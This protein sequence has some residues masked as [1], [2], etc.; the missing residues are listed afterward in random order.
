ML[1]VVGA[2]AALSS[3]GSAQPASSTIE[4]VSAT[5]DGAPSTPDN[6][7][8]RVS[9]DG[10][11]VVFD[12]SLTLDDPTSTTSTTSTTPSPP[13]APVSTAVVTI[14]NRQA[15]TTQR[16][17]DEPSLHPGVSGNG[18]VVAYSVPVSGGQVRLI[19]L[20]RCTNPGG[21]LIGST[22]VVD[23]VTASADPTGAL[24]APALSDDGSVIVWSTGR[25]ITRYVASSTG[26]DEM[27]IPMPTS[28]V[29][30]DPVATGSTVDVSDDGT[31]VVFVAGPGS[32][33]YEPDPANV[34]AWNDDPDDAG[35]QVA[36]T[37]LV[38][39]STTGGPGTGDSAWPSVSGNGRIV[40]Y[41]SSSDDIDASGSATSQTPFVVVVDR[42]AGTAD[43]LVDD[44]SRP[45]I[46]GDGT[47]V[48]HD[49]PTGVELQRWV[50]GGDTPFADT[51]EATLS[52][53]VDG[54]TS[55]GPSVTGPVVSGDGSVAVFDHTSGA[56]LTTDTRFGTGAH[57]WAR[58]T[59]QDEPAVTTTTPGAPG[60][61]TTTPSGGSAPP[62][63]TATR[64]SLP[65]TAGRPPPTTIPATTSSPGRPAPPASSSGSRPPSASGSGSSGN[66]S[67]P[68]GTGSTPTFSTGP[69]EFVAFV[70][71]GVEF[72]PTIVDAGRQTATFSVSNPT[73]NAV[74]VTAV[75]FDGDPDGAFSV[76]ENAC[77]ASPV[78][79]AG[80]CDLA[81][82]YAPVSDGYASAQIVA[83]LSDGSVVYGTVAGTGAPPPVVSV[84]PGV[85][86][87]GQVV[88]I[89]GS[90]FPA[91]V[92]IELSWLGQEPPLRIDVDASGAFVE[93]VIVMSHTPRGPADVTV[94]GQVD[95]F[96][97]VAGE[98]LI[99]D[100][101]DRSSSTLTQTAGGRFAS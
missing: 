55:A 31:V 37:E 24:A 58:P 26:Y 99:T 23:T 20:D 64:P 36:A 16:V 6:L 81:V 52:I 79:P 17:P 5:T 27:V 22:E 39:A 3:P 83:S 67:R 41:E 32:V 18:C 45:S 91:G 62:P 38:S 10:S 77:D 88:A 12:S 34:F 90:G 69:I 70:P 4:I 54:S 9:D 47:A 78:P 100:T 60:T 71:S 8:P 29:G 56:A 44:A 63:S 94:V 25:T 35:P 40:V 80:S 76:L 95:L 21:A 84:V 97:S 49:T 50:G 53:G 72:S 28:I 93:T 86:S 2:G 85:A 57:V 13:T 73:D 87:S 74:S 1:G 14:R 30:S 11:I 66:G 68:V 43:V 65:P 61:P 101:S 92:T 75:T 98:V 59:V 48:V 51:S 15:E 96:D 89:Q 82:S 33:G 42:A 46:S 19:A 7:G